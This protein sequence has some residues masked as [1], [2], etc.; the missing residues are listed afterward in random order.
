MDNADEIVKTVIQRLEQWK[1]EGILREKLK[2]CGLKFQDRQAS[3]KT[4][5]ETPTKNESK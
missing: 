1:R 5:D 3:D 4:D 2:E